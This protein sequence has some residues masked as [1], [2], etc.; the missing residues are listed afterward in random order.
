[1]WYL[2]FFGAF[3]VCNLGAFFP[4]C[5]KINLSIGQQDWKILRVTRIFLCGKMEVMMWDP[6]LFLKFDLQ[7]YMTVWKHT[8]TSAVTVSS[9]TKTHLD[10]TSSKL[11]HVC[12]IC[13]NDLFFVPLKH[14]NIHLKGWMFEKKEVLL[15]VHVSYY[16]R[17]NENH[18]QIHHYTKQTGQIC[19]KHIHQS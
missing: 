12:S 18:V 17:E 11:L 6:F 3:F 15:D 2:D 7:Y 4:C 14:C 9:H 10:I 19:K 8:I 13:Q 5:L 16:N 1:M